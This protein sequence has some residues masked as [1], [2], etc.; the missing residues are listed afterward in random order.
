MWYFDLLLRPFPT[1]RRFERLPGYL[2]LPAAPTIRL[3]G[4][5]PAQD[6][7]AWSLLSEDLRHVLGQ[8]PVRSDGRADVRVSLVSPA[9]SPLRLPAEGYTLHV[10]DAGVELAAQDYRGVLHGLHTFIQL[11]GISRLSDKPGQVTCCHIADWPHFGYRAAL[12]DLGRSV[13][14]RDMLRRL[15]RLL[16]RMKYN[17][18]HLHLNDNELNPVRYPGTPLGAENPH[19][20]ELSDYADLIRYAGSWGIEVVPEVESWGHAGSLLQH[21]P[22]LYGGTRRHGYGYSLGIGQASLDLLSLLYDAWMEI[23]P[24]GSDFHVGLDEGTWG[25]LP[26][27]DPAEFSKETWVP[28]VHAALMAAAQRRGKRVR[29]GVWGDTMIGLPIPA[30][31]RQQ[32]VLQPWSYHTNGNPRVIEEIVRTNAML[33]N[34]YVP[35]RKGPH[36]LVCCMGTSTTCDAGGFDASR[37]WMELVKRSPNVL[38]GTVCLWGINDIAGRLV[39][40]FGG[41]ECMW[42]PSAMREWYGDLNYEDVHSDVSNRMR[43]WQTFSP[44]TDPESLRSAQG[45]VIMHACHRWGPQMGQAIAPIWRHTPPATRA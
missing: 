12:F 21:H 25:L 13:F 3:R 2:A 19:A 7:V 27:A 30:D 40:F 26:G 45:P 42:S 41:A 34:A 9:D 32:I 38:G 24:D 4:L 16:S 36:P 10:S 28:K 11:V 22:H 23:L 1:V 15:V 29:M 6:E 17:K 8:S 44:D 14:S 43:A 5:S 37:R 31:L 20:L 35:D 39:T 33:P 18:L